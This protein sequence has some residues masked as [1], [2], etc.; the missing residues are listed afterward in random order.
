MC[1]VSYVWLI[2]AILSEPAVPELPAPLATPSVIRV[3]KLV[4]SAEQY[5][6]AP[7]G[8]Q[9]RLFADGLRHPR[10]MA[11]A[12]NG[13]VFVVQTRLELPEKNQPHSVV[14]LRD[15]DGDGTAE[16]RSVWS[17]EL[18]YPFGIAFDFGHLYVANTG[19][20]VRWPYQT[21]ARKAP[22][23]PETVLAGIPSNGYRNHWT[24]NIIFSPDNQF[25]FL[26]IG[27]EN[28]VAEEGPRRA[29][30]ERYPLDSGGLIA[31]KGETYA[32]GMRNPIGLDFNPVTGALWANVAERDYLGDELV[33][34]YT[35]AVRQGGFYG[36]P[37]YFI[38]PHHDPRMP[39]RPLLKKKA[40]V[41]DVLQPSH[42][43]PIDILFYRG[44][45]FPAEYRGDAFVALHG[46]QNRKKLNGYKV[47]R[48]R[49]DKYGRATGK[50]EDFVTGW[51]PTGSNREI[52]GR[53]AGLLELAD[54]SLLIADDWG[55]RIWRVSANG[56]P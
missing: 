25:V 5:L 39:E 53:P 17:E 1:L 11:L 15:S 41:P 50:V 22:G 7:N 23:N 21:G 52:H 54:G 26:T 16:S 45:S 18:D 2:A 37:N 47:V 19:S 56:G 35:T 32:S 24:R 12:P 6:R 49:F 10:M 48:I 46:S 44:S 14:V 55:G 40:I 30:I 51:L 20:I 29:V 34:D 27:S 9:V 28:N 36:W 42:S 3:P 33:P 4:P 13:D 31:G 43:T 8:F 38:G